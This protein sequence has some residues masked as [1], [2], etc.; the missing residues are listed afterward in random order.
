MQ[1]ICC[2]LSNFYL[3]S[4]SNLHSAHSSRPSSTQPQA[5]QPVQNTM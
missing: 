2:L 3:E 1:L 5:A 4:N